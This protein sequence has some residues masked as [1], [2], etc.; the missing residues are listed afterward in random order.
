[1]NDNFLKR[2][3]MYVL[4]V[5]A[6]PFFYA[7]YIRCIR[8]WN[9]VKLNPRLHDIIVD[10]FHKLYYGSK[11]YNNAFWLDVPANKCPLDLWIY[12]EIIFKLKPDLIIETGTSH[13]GSALFLASI[14]DLINKGEVVTIDIA[15]VPGRPKHDRIKYLLDSSTSVEVV[16]K[17]KGMV[18][19]D[20]CVLVILDSDHSKEHVLNELRIYSELVTRGSYIIVEDTNVNGHPVLPGWGEGPMEAV[21]EFLAGN[22]LF[23]IDKTREKFFLTFNPKGYLK[24]IA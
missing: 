3:V 10:E 22:K 18:K 13:G 21:Q 20:A 2:S 9:N 23:S 12:Q 15:D 1:M 8:R 7:F 19:K 24:K 5:L 11:R 6:I 14:C 4:N 17:V 16:E